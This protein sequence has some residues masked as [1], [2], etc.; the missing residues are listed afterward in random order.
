MPDTKSPRFFQTWFADAEAERAAA[1]AALAATPASVAPKFFYD[2]LGSHLFEAIT[3]LAEYYPTR[4]EAVIFAAHGAAMTEAIG[5]GMALVDLGAGNCAKAASLFPLFEPRRYV[6]VD[7]SVEFLRDALRQL[8]RDHPQVQITGLGQDFSTTLDIAAELIG[9]DRPVFFYPGS[10]IGNFTTDEALAFLGR[11]RE[12]AAGGGLL[13]GVD[14]VKS[15]AVLEAAYDDALGVTAAFNRNALIHLNRLIGSDFAP[16]QWRHV[17]FFDDANSRIEMH[18]E[19]RAP[20]DV[21]W[22]GGGRRFAAGERIHTENSCK[23]TPDGFAELLVAA[24][25]ETPRCWTDRQGWFA[26]FWAPAR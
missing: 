15:R 1:R 10:S 6:A 16:R 23:Y 3:E 2:R 18:L 7:I 21:G 13:I 8:Q 24:G 14:L 4:T 12:R 25:F 22:P 20:I 17:A 9:D 26:V 11:V 5:A 19:A